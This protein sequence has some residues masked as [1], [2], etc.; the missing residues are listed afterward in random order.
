[1][2]ACHDTGI[3]AVFLQYLQGRVDTAGPV[4]FKL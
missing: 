3:V 1:V 4:V 2:P